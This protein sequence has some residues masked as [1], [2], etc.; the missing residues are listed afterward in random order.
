MDL[1]EEDCDTSNWIALAEVRDQ[2]RV[3]ITAIMNLLV[4]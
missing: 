4:S 3:Y 2:W 1:R